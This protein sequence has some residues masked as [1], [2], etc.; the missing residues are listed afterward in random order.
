[1][2]WM[3]GVCCGKVFSEFIGG[4]RDKAAG[5]SSGRSKT[6]DPSL[7]WTRFEGSATLL[8]FLL[9]EVGLGVR[10]PSSLVGF[11]REMSR[12]ANSELWR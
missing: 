10:P 9:D 3:V 6:E 7:K 5:F 4:G 12:C 1:M 8:S 11:G 2:L